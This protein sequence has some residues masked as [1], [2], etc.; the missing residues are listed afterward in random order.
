[1]VG[2][3]GVKEINITTIFIIISEQL[4]ILSY[5]TVSIQNSFSVNTD[6][7]QLIFVVVVFVERKIQYMNC[8]YQ[9]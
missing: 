3:G 9:I 2:G 7:V 5:Q 4:A 1:M 8:V 6:M